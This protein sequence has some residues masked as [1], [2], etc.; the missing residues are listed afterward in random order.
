MATELTTKQEKWKEAF[1]SGLP[2]IDCS[3][4]AGYKG[5]DNVLS[6][7]AFKNIR[8]G[9]IKQ[10]I[11]EH[12]AKIEAETEYTV[13]QWLT[14]ALDARDKALTA[15]QYSAVAAFD[16]LI[17]QH[18]GVFELDNLQ[19]GEQVALDERKRAEAVRIANIRCLN[20]D[21]VDNA[22]RAG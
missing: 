21:R 18:K 8:N 15:K 3:R 6:Q 9:K 13:K 16:R 4:I 1:I 19:K 20:L 22:Q 7:V 5:N 12:R 17:G 11:D 2:G 14:D 10:A